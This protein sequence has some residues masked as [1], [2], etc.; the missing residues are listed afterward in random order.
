MTRPMTERLL[1][2]SKITAWLDCAHSLTL[3][4]RVE[5]GSLVLDRQPFGS[6][7]QLLMEK[8]LQHEQDCLEE[9]RRRGRTV[10]EVPGR[11][12]GEPFA[13][14]VDR[15]GEVLAA[16]HDVIYQV[17]LVH[18]GARGIA[19]FLLRVEDPH[20]GA[21]T[22]EPVDAKLARSE[23]KPGHVLQLCFYADA[24][25]VATG[26]AP[27]QVHLWLGSGRFETLHT[28]EVRPYWNRLRSQLDAL[29]TAPRPD[30]ETEPEP[31]AH[32]EFCNFA[33][34]CEDHWRSR[35]SLINVAGIRRSDRATL[36]GPG[37]T[38]IQALALRTEA[39]ESMQ[40][41]RLARLSG[42][43]ALQVAARNAPDR[44][45]PVRVVEPSDDPVWGRGFELM[46]EPDDGDVFLDFEGHPFW[47]ADTGLFFLFGY[48][49]KDDGGEWS[50]DALW[51]HD[52][53]EE[54]RATRDLI[55]FFVQRRAKHPGMHVYHYN[56]TERSA[57]E[58]LVSDHGVGEAALEHLVET[59]LFVDLLTVARNAVQ[60]GTESYGLKH[61]EQLT[62]YERGHDIDQG[63][64]AVV[65]YEAYTRNRD[66]QSLVRIAAYNEDDVRATRAL[67]DWLLQQR[68]TGLPWRAATIDVEEEHPEL[69]E[70]VAAL[71][72]YGDGT[73]EHLLGEVLG[74]WLR[75]WRAC[76]APKL[77]KI[78]GDTPSLLDEPDVVAGLIPVGPTVRT[79]KNGRVLTP[80]M[81]F[82]FPAQEIADEV[83]TSRSSNVL[84]GASDGA[85]G[86]SSIHR[87][88]RDEGTI[89]L[90]WNE[91]AQELGV[92]PTS[93]ILN[94][95]VPPKPKPEA[96]SE[97]ADAVLGTS[98][99]PNPVAMALLRRD[100]PRFATGH[101]PAGGMFTDDLAEMVENVRHLDRSCLAIQ[102]PPGTGKTFRGAH[103]VHSLISA[104]KRVGITAFSHQAIDNLLAEVVEV[105]S[106]EGDLD[107][108]HAVRR[109]SAPRSG[110]L[111]SVT[112]TTANTKCAKQ[113]FDLV[114]GTTWLFAGNDMYDA[115]VDVLII[116]EAGQLSLADAL[117][118]CRSAANVILLGDPQQLPQVAQASHPGG[119]GASVLEHLLGEHATITSDRGVFLA[120]TRRMHP[121][122]CAFI[123]E[124]IY[125]GRLTSHPTC[126]VQDT[127]DGTGARWIRAHH[128]GSSTHSVEEAELVAREIARLMGTGWV[129]RDGVRAPL[130]PTDFMVVAPYNDQVQL[131][132]ARLDA[133]PRTFGVPVG[134]VD[135]FQGSQAAVVFFTMTTSSA[136]DM[137]RGPDFLFSRNRLNVAISR[138]RCL[139]Y[140]VCTE[141]LL[142]SRARD[143]EEMR[144]IATL[145]AFV[146][147]CERSRPT[148]W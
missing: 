105:F 35:D 52:R 132:R 27:Q 78:A 116:D 19:D 142:N 88:D 138:A 60:V 82:R 145:C 114:A 93:I 122:V 2:P 98:G 62:G 29:L 118:A 61:L 123:S 40:P 11:A 54:A 10:F 96:L 47:R 71:H 6:L 17:P 80:G 139:A 15:L 34:L 128:V 84:Y 87:I 74:Y 1:T 30:E 91:R 18:N 9:Y 90:S 143:V 140:L 67:R 111:P 103:I 94:D 51:A 20:T 144:L 126:A 46:P 3:R 112:Y 8:G 38:T 119:S 26:V 113:E 7:A 55:D 53:E 64:G 41:E 135:K 124:R 147:Y 134:T 56:H 95:W 81:E 21:V 16:G 120:E 48:I 49:A 136:D 36:E 92:V 141:E 117:A 31:C 12:E 25:E 130:A 97:L 22:Y 42:Q 63:A 109:R 83:G 57:L 110:A 4:H 43:A 101:G 75:E 23:A 76:K 50:F 14:W 100:L 5:D 108:L 28:E 65:E 13:A 127:D 125:E 69:D 32:C 79:G 66:D 85:T 146:E 37:V 45:P 133:D 24:I 115:P 59:G 129:D 121:D 68:P 77:A 86:Y 131:L 33:P 106:D 58:R 102:G 72:S 104:G 44:P 39:V 99:S 107:Q 148:R 137:P 89:E 73:P 70:Q